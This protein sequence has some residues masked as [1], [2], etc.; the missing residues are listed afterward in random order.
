M[1]LLPKNTNFFLSLHRLHNKV[2]L[3][4]GTFN[5]R[6]NV[7]S[8]FTWD[9]ENCLLYWLQMLQNQFSQTVKPISK[10]S[11]L[12]GLTFWKFSRI[13]LKNGE[14]HFKNL[15]F[16]RY[17]YP[18]FNIMNERH[19][20]NLGCFL[21][22]SISFQVCFWLIVKFVKVSFLGLRVYGASQKNLQK[23]QSFLKKRRI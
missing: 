4:D 1:L 22:F 11:G 14:M 8:A 5:Y 9:L 15:A 13:M 18:F 19:K 3:C 2:Y 16:I 10:I 12:L 17:L 7:S 6:W 23:W 20:A 21:K